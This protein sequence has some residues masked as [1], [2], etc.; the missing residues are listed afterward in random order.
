ML[1]FVW[2]SQITLET[3]LEGESEVYVPSIRELVLQG[4]GKIKRFCT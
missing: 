2:S 1:V 4:R 3:V